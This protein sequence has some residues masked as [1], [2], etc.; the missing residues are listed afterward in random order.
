VALDDIGTG[1]SNLDR[2]ALLK[3]DILKID[4][5]L[6]RG[7]ESDFYKQEVFKA[8]SSLSQRIGAMVLAEGVESASEAMICLELGAEYVQGFHLARPSAPDDA[9]MQSAELN[10]RA[11]AAEFRDAMVGNLRH[12]RRQHQCFAFVFN[13]ALACVSGERVEDMSAA[14]AEAITQSAGIEQLFVLDA[15]GLQVAGVAGGKAPAQPSPL[16]HPH[17]LG[18]DHSMKDYYYLTYDSSIKRYTTEPHISL[19]TG[20]LC[21]TLAGWFRAAGSNSEYMLGMDVRPDIQWKG[22]D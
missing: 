1:H 22:E 14:L 7:I 13:R 15:Q 21:V 4:D 3:P 18:T 17:D 2:I 20:R 12:R 9:S 16:F 10:A 19:A 8:L 6:I 11:M 5:S